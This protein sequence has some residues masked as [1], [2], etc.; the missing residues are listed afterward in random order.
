MASVGDK[1]RVL[2]NK[3]GQPPREG[4]VTAMNG[5]LLRIRWSTGEETSFVP[6]AGSVIVVGK[7]TARSPS[8]IGAKST[9]R[10]SSRSKK[11]Q[12]LARPITSKKAAPK[13]SK[14]HKK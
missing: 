1:V 7:A 2:P 8:T 4:I 12:D 6:G 10:A 13:P 9:K 14:D 3:A 11:D 5:S